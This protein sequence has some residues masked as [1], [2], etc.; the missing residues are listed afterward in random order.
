MPFSLKIAPGDGT[1]GSANPNNIDESSLKRVGF[2]L[3]SNE[4]AED[5]LFSRMGGWNVV[6]RS[7]IIRVRCFF[8]PPPIVY[9]VLTSRLFF[10]SPS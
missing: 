1:F 7:S 10:R 3:S 2:N 9:I 8:H 4:V 6:F 5:Y